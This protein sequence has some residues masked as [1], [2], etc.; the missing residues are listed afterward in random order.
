[1]ANLKEIRV[2]IAS[3]VSTRQITSAMKM[4][5]AAKLKKVQNAITTLRPYADKMQN[6]M[7]Q[8]SSSVDA[9]D[10]NI[11]SEKRDYGQVLIVVMT[12]NR[13]L[14]GAFN[15]N[16]VKESQRLAETKYGDLL[17]QGK[18]RFIAVG[19]KGY[20]LLRKRNLPIDEYITK[21][22]DQLIYEDAVSF[23]QSLMDAFVSKRY[24]CIDIVYNKFVNPAVQ[25]VMCH[26]FLPLQPKE[27]SRTT[28]YI[29]YLFEP[30]KEYIINE[31]VPK[32]LRLTV[33]Q[34]LLDSSASEFGARMTSMHQA[35][36]N[37]TSLI[38][39][40]TLQYNKA[41]QAA[42]TN[43]ILEIVGGAEALAG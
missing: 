32:S 43:E 41:R 5:A 3:V 37:A 18:V 19:K 11:Y 30:S 20:D 17:S 16:A 12:S 29:D 22:V 21:L 10:D 7:A 33:Y 8:V 23:A 14:C 28:K 2:R 39:E 24:D 4:V 15:S 40:L 6:I 34:A 31:L 35:T 27:E 38:Q 26:Q 13:G 1:M 36:D 25:K 9:D 42:I